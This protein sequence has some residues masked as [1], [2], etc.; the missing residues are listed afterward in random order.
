MASGK[1]PSGEYSAH[2]AH[3][4][5]IAVLENRVN[6]HSETIHRHDVRL[7]EGDVMLSEMNTELTHMRKSVDSCTE[8]IHSAVRWVLGIVGTSAFGG[9]LYSILQSH[10][11]GIIK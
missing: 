11:A 7:G 3:E 6:S 10:N 2:E 4:P 1:I 9:I 5:R 8:A